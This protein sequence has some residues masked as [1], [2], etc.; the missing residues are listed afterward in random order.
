[1]QGQKKMNKIEEA[2]IDIGGIVEWFNRATPNPSIEDV[3]V[4]CGCHYEEV[5]EFQEALAR[6]TQ[7]E[8]H[9]KRY[10]DKFKQKE[11]EAIK[12]LELV[13][14]SKERSV[15]LLDAMID[16]VYTVIGI[17]VRM[18]F[19]MQGAINEVAASNWSKFE[20]GKPVFDENG[21]IAKGKDY[22]KPDLV[23]FTKFGKVQD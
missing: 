21:K 10:A 11:P 6:G 4:Q 1:M 13:S 12:S 15:S 23:K 14:E 22:F 8:A 2:N 19:D 7:L 16:Q 3:S 20:N 17:G 9:I 18:G 5:A